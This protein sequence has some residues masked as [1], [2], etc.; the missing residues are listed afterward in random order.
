[1]LFTY[2]DI[3]YVPTFLNVCHLVIENE[4]HPDFIFYD[5]LMN[6]PVKNTVILNHYQQQVS[7]PKLNQIDIGSFIAR[8]Q[9]IK[10]VGFSSKAFNADGI[11]VEDLL[12]QF[13]DLNLF[14]INQALFVHN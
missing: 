9:L 1:M 13:S 7:L 2:V 12:K 8:S 5:C 6:I 10:D 14:K 4:T 3:Y 11:L